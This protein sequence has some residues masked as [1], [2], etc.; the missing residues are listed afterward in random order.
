MKISDYAFLSDCQSAALV[1]LDGSVDWFCTPR[2]DSPSIFGRLLDP[3][4][5][6]WQIRP[7]GKYTASRSYEGETLVLRTIFETAAGQVEL[8][9]ALALEPGSEGHDIGKSVPH[10]LLRSVRGISGS[11]EMEFEFRPRFEYGLTEAHFEKT[12]AGLVASGGKTQLLLAGPVPLELSRSRA[13]SR[14]TLAAGDRAAFSLTCG[15]AFGP[16]P[17]PPPDAG[18]AI[19][20]TVRSWQ[21]WMQPHRSYQGLYLD[22]VRQGALVLQGLTYQPS[23]AVIAAATTSLPEIMGGE[24]NWDYR[25]VWLRDASM[26]MDALWV[27]ACPDEP[28]RFF[29]WISRAGGRSGREAV[30]I[31]YGVEGERDLTERTLGHLR[32]FAGSR[33]VRVGN[34]AWRQKQLDVLGE[35]LDTAY[36]LRDRLDLVFNG[37]SREMLISFAE[38]AAR[39]WREPDAG[40]WE[41][42]D[43]ERHYLS[44]KVMCWVALD[45]AV[46]LAERLG[47]ADRKEGWARAREEVRQAVL[48]EGWSEEAGAYTG[49]FGS[50]RLDASVLLLPL[51]GFLPATDPRMR[52]TIAAVE[53]ELGSQQTGLV[54][55][56]PEEP[57]GFIICSYWL[58]EC[59]ALAGDPARAR[60]IFEQV[61]ALA[62]DVGLLA[63]EADART[64]QLLGNFPQ[65]FSHVGLINAAW[66]LTEAQPDGGEG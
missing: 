39:D 27:A 63:E 29:D 20:D 60:E 50:A 57:N 5:G 47:A 13:R 36:L 7:A 45:R 3:D 38:R 64:G 14:F 46:R 11:V 51:T 41:A 53:R 37:S 18:G 32:G 10:A 42:R 52:A 6:H 56:W 40:M 9:E 49:A 65:A 24:A 59:K 22:H 30:Q 54:R 66:R 48:T 44:S 25:Y 1:S 23:G 17:E 8:V 43:S 61:T 33:P 21:S 55:R 58:A 2:F 19:D 12:Q 16:R 62:N 15:P 28:E 31:M 26:M 34:E 35:V 4:A